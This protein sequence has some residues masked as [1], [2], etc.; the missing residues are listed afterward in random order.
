MLDVG[1]MA[2]TRGRER[3]AEDFQ[4]LFDA[5]GLRLLRIVAPTAPSTLS[6]VEGGL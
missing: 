4:R 6:I 1:I 2:L 5:A 3:T